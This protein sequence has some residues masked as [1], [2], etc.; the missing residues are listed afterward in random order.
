MAGDNYWPALVKQEK[1]STPGN[2][3]LGGGIMSPTSTNFLWSD[4]PVP[5]RRRRIRNFATYVMAFRRPIRFFI[6]HIHPQALDDSLKLKPSCDSFKEEPL[7]KDQTCVDS[8]HAFIQ[9]QSELL[10]LKRAIII[11]RLPCHSIHGLYLLLTTD[12]SQLSAPKQ[13]VEEL[14]SLVHHLYIIFPETKARAG[15]WR[16][17]IEGV[18]GIPR[19][20]TVG[21]E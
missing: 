16:I 17:W 5:R 18:E 3:S 9:K 20:Y 2:W 11:F 12:F 1:S 13:P 15:I 21:P 10:F 6:L 19:D 4:L 14:R 8:I 7:G